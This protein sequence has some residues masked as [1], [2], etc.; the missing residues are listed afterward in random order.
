LLNV[1]KIKVSLNSV[2][3]IENVIV[4]ASSHLNVCVDASEISV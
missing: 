2:I 1:N 4:T 3:L